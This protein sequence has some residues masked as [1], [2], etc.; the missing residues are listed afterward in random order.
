MTTNTHPLD[1]LDDHDDLELFAEELG[2]NL[3][4]GTGCIS[5]ASSFGCAG[6]TFSTVATLSSQSG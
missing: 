2:E 3:Q 5:T 6:T 4:H 1:L